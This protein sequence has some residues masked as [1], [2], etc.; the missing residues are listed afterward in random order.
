MLETSLT[1]YDINNIIDKYY[2]ENPSKKLNFVKIKKSNEPKSNYEFKNLI[3]F[4]GV[5]CRN[6][7]DLHLDKCPQCSPELKKIDKIESDK[8]KASSNTRSNIIAFLLNEKFNI[9]SDNKN[10][11]DLVEN[12]LVYSSNFS[13][14]FNNTESNEFVKSSS[15]FLKQR[16]ESLS[17]KSD[18]SYKINHNKH[19]PSENYFTDL[20]DLRKKVYSKKE[21]IK[22][23]TS[24]VPFCSNKMYDQIYKFD[25]SQNYKLTSAKSC[26]TYDLKELIRRSQ[27]IN[28]K[29]KAR[30]LETRFEKI[31][32]KKCLKA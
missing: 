31:R 3:R 8:P 9:Q 21:P 17:K 4:N 14:P 27:I 5:I 13:I 29:V 30:E 15:D 19:I 20:K 25:I 22:L 2:V 1:G 26:L 32:F 7:V 18:D 23:I 11:E 12:N 24:P 16:R 10:L 6:C 28:S